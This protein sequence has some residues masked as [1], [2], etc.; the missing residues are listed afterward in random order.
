LLSY[1]AK[2]EGGEVMAN[3]EAELLYEYEEEDD[4][5]DDDFFD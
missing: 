1:E 3:I 5:D 2:C 4:A